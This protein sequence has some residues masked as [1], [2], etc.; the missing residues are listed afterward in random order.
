MLCAVTE[1]P[2]DC[3]DDIGHLLLSHRRKD[4]KADLSFIK[5]FRRRTEALSVAHL[6]IN[7]MPVNRKIVNLTPNP[8]S[9]RRRKISFFCVLKESFNR[10]G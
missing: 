1:D 2:I 9:R 3:L 5:V 7:R 4:R 8:C 6:P 10:I